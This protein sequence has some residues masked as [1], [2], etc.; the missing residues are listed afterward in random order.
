MARI[1]QHPNVYPWVCRPAKQTGRHCEKCKSREV[2]KGSIREQ[3]CVWCACKINLIYGSSPPNQWYSDHRNDEVI[4]RMDSTALQAARLDDAKREERRTYERSYRSQLSDAERQRRLEAERRYRK[5]NRER[6][7]ATASRQWLEQKRERRTAAYKKW[8]S[9]NRERV[10]ALARKWNANNKERVRATSRRYRA[11][12]GA[13]LSA[14]QKRYRKANRERLNAKQR[15]WIAAK[16][17]AKAA[18][19]DEKLALALDWLLNVGGNIRAE[20]SGASSH[21]KSSTAQE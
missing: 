11:E 6:V 9:N 14:Y 8:A 15:A 13:K 7:K 2:C 10:N 18:A 12:H 16:Q 4:E 5:A 21:K 19:V 3:H 17:K 20:D 1:K